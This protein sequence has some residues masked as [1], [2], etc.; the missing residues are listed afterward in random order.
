VIVIIFS[1]TWP[2]EVYPH[3]HYSACGQ[4]A[5]F[6]SLSSPSPLSFFSSFIGCI[7]NP[8][9]CKISSSS[10]VFSLCSSNSLSAFSTSFVLSYQYSSFS[11]M[12]CLKLNWV[13][14]L[15]SSVLWYHI[16]VICL[17]G[18]KHRNT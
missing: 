9:L 8:H 17:C 14:N 10:S 13:M 1:F 11:C 16:V 12:S 2:P 6:F 3:C 7:C 15:A 18:E 4:F 5:F